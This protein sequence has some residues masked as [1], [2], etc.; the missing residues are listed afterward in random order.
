MTPFSLSLRYGGFYG[1]L[2][3]VLGIA[4]PFWPLWLEHRGLSPAEIGLLF[5]LTSWS[6]VLTTPALAQLAD[7]S[8]RANGVLILLA[9]V[10]L[11]GNAAMLP[12]YGFWQ[13][14]PLQILGAAAFHALLPI[15]E[16]Q[17]MAAVRRDKLDY[18]RIRLWGS[19]TFI[20]GALGVGQLITGR[21][22]DLVLWL[23]LSALLLTLLATVFL[24][25]AAS[26]AT[27]P[28]K[29]ALWGLLKPG[30]FLWFLIAAGLV[31]A[32]HAVYY[33]FSTL[34][35]Q[36]ASLSGVTIGWLWAEGV[37]AE[38]LL[39]ALA[40][41]LIGER[42][43]VLLLMLAA[44]AGVVR[45]TVLGST[46][47]LPALAAAQVLHGATFGLAHLGAMAWIARAAPG[48]LAASAQSLYSAV[49]GGLIMG[50]AMLASGGLYEA[51]GG[52]AF[53]AMAG[54]SAGGLVLAGWMYFRDDRSLARH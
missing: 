27:R 5:A 43:P 42:S 22:A 18:G 52:S 10:A 41:R 40:G 13:I 37:I 53:Y 6:R 31:Q 47:A 49:S 17:T 29:G 2:F 1:G 48:G 8:G 38:I 30:P 44:L 20:L 15:G 32:G 14:M 51:L 7:R 9:A 39:F 54:L 33:G 4:L 21:T 12:A 23:A 34:H 50:F 26:R 11:C 25:K 45:W 35:W 3:L 24:P 19:L 28:E 36:A 46:T 16:S